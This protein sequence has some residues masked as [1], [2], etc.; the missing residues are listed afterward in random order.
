MTSTSLQ[1]SSPLFT[2]EQLELIRRLKNSGINKDEIV[3]AFDSFEKIDKEI[4]PIYNIPVAL[5]LQAQALQLMAFSLTNSPAIASSSSQPSPAANF[6]KSSL[7]Q[8]QV[9]NLVIPPNE[10]SISQEKKIHSDNAMPDKSD[11]IYDPDVDTQEF[12]N[13]LNQGEVLCCEEIRSFAIKHNIKQQQIATLAGSGKL[14]AVKAALRTILPL[15]GCIGFAANAAQH[16]LNA[17][18]NNTVN[19][20]FIHPSS[21]DSLDLSSSDTSFPR[22]ERFVFRPSHLEILEKY[23]LENNYPT[24]ETREEIALACNTVTESAA[25]RELT[26]REKVTAQIISNWFANKRKELKKLA[27]EEGLLDISLTRPRGHPSRL[28]SDLALIQHNKHNDNNIVTSSE[29]QLA[30][31][32]D[33]ITDT[34]N[35]NECNDDLKTS[36]DDK[37]ANSS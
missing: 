4:G 28:Y 24:Y 12:L 21:I 19:R 10:S 23:F 9:S 35:V 32:H 20:K 26:E 17:N 22:R 3:S 27:K 33:F 13:F 34:N 5:A 30:D 7:P 16:L 14:F 2:V 11:V 1:S 15:K 6:L 8:I 31:T 18:S 29:T 37:I 25:G 36:L